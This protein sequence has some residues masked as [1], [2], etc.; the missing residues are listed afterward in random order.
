MLARCALIATL[1]PVILRFDLVRV[2][3]FLEP[4]REAKRGCRRSALP[5]IHVRVEM[6]ERWVDAVLRHGAPLVRPSCTRRG[7]ALYYGL[8]RLGVDVALCF[9]VDTSGASTVGHCWIAVDGRPAF[10]RSDPCARFREVA[11]I[12]RCGVET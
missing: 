7:I 1:A 2:Q 11:R 9:G 5:P 12:S 4:A 10:E 3:R 6:L 8:R